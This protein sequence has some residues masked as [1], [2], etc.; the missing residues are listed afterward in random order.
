MSALLLFA[1][2][3]LTRIFYVA[4]E[5]PYFSGPWLYAFWALE[6]FL[7]ILWTGVS[8]KAAAG[9]HGFVFCEKCNREAKVLFKSPLLQPLPDEFGTALMRFRS[10]LEEG[11]F[12]ALESLPVAGAVSEPGTFSRLILRGCKKCQNFYCADVAKVE[13]KWDGDD[14]QDTDLREVDDEDNL[15]VEHL[16]LPT[17]WYVRLRAHFEASTSSVQ[18]ATDEEGRG[19][20]I[21]FVVA[22]VMVLAMFA[23]LV[24]NL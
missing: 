16:L 3:Y 8:C 7:T 10:R 1:V 18:S 11:H 14:Y 13:V 21:I 20:L 5:F 23:V 17:S 15:I 12:D 9:K 22:G 6:A 24:F 4:V 2:A 19:W